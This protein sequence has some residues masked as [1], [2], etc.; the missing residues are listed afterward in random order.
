MTATDQEEWP[1]DAFHHW[2]AFHHW[3]TSQGTAISSPELTQM[4][5]KVAENVYAERKQIADAVKAAR[6]LGLIQ[7]LDDIVFERTQFLR[8]ICT[9]RFK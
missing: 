6:R 4:T 3:F 5:V 9:A 7:P 2:L 8:S 1:P